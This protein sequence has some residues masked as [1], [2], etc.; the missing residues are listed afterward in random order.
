MK[1]QAERR[2][3]KLNSALQASQ[4]SRSKFLTPWPL[5]MQLA[6]VKEQAERRIAQLNSALQAAESRCH[7]L[8]SEAAAV[9]AATQTAP[10]ALAQPAQVQRCLLSVFQA[11]RLVSVVGPDK[12][13]RW[14]PMPPPP[15]LSRLQRPPP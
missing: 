1:E 8:A 5:Y 13:A 10:A 11:D 15:V 9:A 6:E 7:Q 4:M 12:F 14:R 2:I 3:A